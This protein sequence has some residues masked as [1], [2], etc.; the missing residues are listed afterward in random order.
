MFA[1]IF[2]K[3]TDTI[4]DERALILPFVTLET[5]PYVMLAM[6]SEFGG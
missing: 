2:L 3:H 4:G 5:V 1:I 6:V